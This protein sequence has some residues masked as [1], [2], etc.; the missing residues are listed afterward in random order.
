MED[1]RLLW[2]VVSWFLISNCRSFWQCASLRCHH[3]LCTVP[4]SQAARDCP[5]PQPG[6]DG[7]HGGV[8]RRS[9]RRRGTEDVGS[10]DRDYAHV[11]GRIRFAVCDPH[12]PCSVLGLVGRCAP[13]DL[14]PSSRVQPMTWIGGFVVRP[15]WEA[16]KGRC[17][18]TCT[19]GDRT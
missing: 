10:E 1:E 19:R 13:H 12:V 14:W 17:Q 15:S 7:N 18:T 8:A 6:H 5:R 11:H 9:T 4:P 3:L 2:E 16:L